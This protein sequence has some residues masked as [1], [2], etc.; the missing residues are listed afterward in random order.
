MTPE[1]QHRPRS[2]VERA[3]AIIALIVGC[4]AIVP[5]ML[6]GGAGV[7]N[8]SESSDATVAVWIWIVIYGI[9]GLVLVSRARLAHLPIRHSG[10]VL[11]LSVLAVTSA[12]W[13]VD[14]SLTLRRGSALICTVGFG[15]YL[16]TSYDSRELLSILSW[17]CGL[18]VM[19]SVLLVI[20]APGYG[21][22]PVRGDAWRGVLATKNELGR[23]AA[24][25]LV[26]WG[27]RI[28]LRMGPRLVSIAMLVLCG[29]AV[30]GSNSRTASIVV[31]AVGALGLLAVIAAINRRLA[32]AAWTALASVSFVAATWLLNNPGVGTV[33]IVGDPT[34]TG[35]TQLWAAVLQSIAQRPWLGYGYGAFWKGVAGPSAE[36]ISIVHWAPPHSH[37]GLLDIC[38]DLGVVGGAIAIATVGYAAFASVRAALR[39]PLTIEGFLPIVLVAFLF[40]YNITETGLLSRNLIYPMLLVIVLHLSSLTR[41]APLNDVRRTNGTAP[42]LSVSQ[43]SIVSDRPIGGRVRDL[44]ALRAT[45][46]RRADPA[47]SW[48]DATTSRISGFDRQC[49]NPLCLPGRDY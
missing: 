16:C 1:A 34:L 28:V 35:R 37:N 14:P 31:V 26:L 10:P 19:M 36:V 13:S 46:I 3:F 23:I 29:A 43:V 33:D 42:V 41:S 11:A 18:V 40:L 6:V 12:L 21:L 17:A 24:L 39:S 49:Q 4:N 32:V 7:A 20:V 45:G 15:I 5:L 44:G 38:L 47:G 2:A 27:T 30:V 25:A 22:D 9:S 8:A 48:A